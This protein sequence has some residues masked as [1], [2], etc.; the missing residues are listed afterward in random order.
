MTRALRSR[1]SHPRRTLNVEEKTAQN[2][3][4]HARV[5]ARNIDRYLR[6]QPPVAYRPRTGPLVISLGDATGILMFK[7]FV[8]VGRVPGALKWAIE[9]MEL[10]RYGG[11]VPWARV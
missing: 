10:A 1:S 2:A 4:R 9:R 8:W 6:G 11:F 5:I 3:Q 7:D